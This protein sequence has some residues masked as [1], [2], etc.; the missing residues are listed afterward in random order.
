MAKKKQTFETALNRL[1]SIV[2]ALASDGEV[3]LAESVKL[4]KEGIDMA[5]L[6]A[7]SLEQA[8]AAVQLLRQ[9]ESGAFI[10]EAFAEDAE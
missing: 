6:C 1:E 5:Q 9:D 10:L 7:E 8:E 4:Y 2:E 3:T